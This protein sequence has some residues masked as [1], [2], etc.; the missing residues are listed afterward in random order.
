[1]NKYVQFLI[2]FF[3]ISVSLQSSDQLSDCPIKSSDR[4]LTFAES[5]FAGGLAGAG[6]VFLPGHILSK[7]MNQAIKKESMV[8]KEVHE[9]FFTNLTAQFAITAVSHSVNVTGSQLIEHVQKSPLTQEQIVVMSLVSGVAAGVVDTISN[10]IQLRQQ[11]PEGKG[12]HAIQALSKLGVSSLRGVTPTGIKEAKFALAWQCAAAQ[13]EDFVA[14]YI[15]NK[16]IAKALGGAGIGVATAV[17]THPWAVIRNTMQ[18]DVDAV[19][20]KTTVQTVQKIYTQE[21]FSGFIKGLSQRGLRVAIAIPLYAEYSK[22]LG[23]W[24]KENR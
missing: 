17:V 8:W 16:R 9:G 13:G 11:R 10:S 23:Q 19:I 4:P 20:Y 18:A 2:I 15:D 14:E 12:E 3:M 22:K 7:W 5:I 6:E 21:G 1:M 24:I